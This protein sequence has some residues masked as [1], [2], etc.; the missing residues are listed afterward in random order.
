MGIKTSTNKAAMIE[1]KRFMSKNESGIWLVKHSYGYGGFG[2]HLCFNLT[3][4]QNY[5]KERRGSGSVVNNNL[6]IQQ[7]I[8]APLLYENK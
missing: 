8:S 1:E 2:I 6:V 3:K 7:Y 5:I 4:I